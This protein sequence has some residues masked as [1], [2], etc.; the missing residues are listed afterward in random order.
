MQFNLLIGNTG[1]HVI[2]LRTAI[3]MQQQGGCIVAHCGGRFVKQEQWE[4]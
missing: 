2:Q 1:V 4:R 3:R